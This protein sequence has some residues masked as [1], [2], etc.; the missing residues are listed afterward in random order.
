MTS[1]DS[2][3]TGLSSHPETWPLPF[4][5]GDPNAGTVEAL[6]PRHGVSMGRIQYE[7]VT[8]SYTIIRAGK[9]G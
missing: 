2:S 3:D 4:P 8:K 7:K 5:G 1:V 9:D 6:T